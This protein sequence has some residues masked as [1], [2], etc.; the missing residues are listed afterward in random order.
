LPPGPTHLGV[1]GVESVS[2]TAL[3]LGQKLIVLQRTLRLSPEETHLIASLAGNVV[4]LELTLNIDIDPQGH[5]TLLYRYQVLNLCDKSLTRLPREIW[6]KHTD[7]GIKIT[8]VEG[9]N[10]RTSIQLVHPTPGLVKFACQVSPPIQP[11]EAAIVQYTCLGGRFVDEYYWRQA[12]PRYVRHFTL[13][14]RHR[15]AGRLVDC[16]AIEEH[17]DGSETSIPQHLLWDCEGNDIII[18]LTKDYLSPNQAM[19]LRWEATGEPTG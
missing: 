14:L 18:T 11:G 6:F 5:A 17:A 16:T 7:G 2:G 9:I 13:H 12:M 4:E 15:N 3:E 1:Q 8:P 10:H 19:T